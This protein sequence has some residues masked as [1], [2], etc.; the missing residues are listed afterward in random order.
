ME[1]KT[2]KTNE[3][4]KDETKV[5]SPRQ[6]SQER[7]VDVIVASIERAKTN[8]GTLLNATQKTRPAIYDSKM[9]Q[10]PFNNLLIAM[11]SDQNDQ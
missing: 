3:T 5:E 7:I 10:S 8:G 9:Q 2:S 11:H 1:D 6:S 4:Q